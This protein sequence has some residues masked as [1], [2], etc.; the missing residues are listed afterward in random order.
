MG[1]NLSSSNS[2]VRNI[3]TK[4]L[5]P[6]TTSEDFKIYLANIQFLQ[7]ASNVLT[8][9]Y[10][11]K[12]H[13][14]F[15]K[16]YR[17]MVA[18]TATAAQEAFQQ[19]QQQKE[20]AAHKGQHESTKA[21]GEAATTAGTKMMLLHSDSLH[22]P[23]VCDD[24]SYEEEHKRMVLKI[25]QEFWDLPTNYQE[26]PLVFGSQAKNRY[27]TILPN[28][29]SRV[30]LEPE[31]SPAAGG[32]PYI[33]ANYIKVRHTEQQPP[34]MNCAIVNPLFLSFSFPPQKKRVPIMRTIVTSLR[35]A[36]CRTRS[37]SFG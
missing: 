26:K 34:K 27:K 13:N 36:P 28:E 10:L 21:D 31:R 37:T 33:N 14:F 1:G 3:S 25:H 23:P 24:E 7:N 18:A 4:P 8:M 32:E 2:N 29:H 15:T 20:D 6:Q 11:R 30:I 35:R 16:T 17:K 9:A 19:Q 12:L 5:S 22:H